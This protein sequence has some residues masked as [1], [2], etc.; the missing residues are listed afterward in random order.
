MR[1][2]DR[3][4][5]SLEKIYRGAFTAAEEAE[6]TETMARLDI[7]YQRDQLELELLLDIREL[8]MPEEKD[9]TTSLLEKA[10]QLRQLTKLR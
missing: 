10:Q 8:L 6:D 5:Q 3:V 9:K 7:G 1:S 2:R 4:L